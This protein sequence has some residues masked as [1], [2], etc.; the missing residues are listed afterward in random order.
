MNTFT[1]LTHTGISAA[2][3]NPTLIEAHGKLEGAY[4]PQTFKTGVYSTVSNMIPKEAY[5]T[6]I[7]PENAWISPRS[8]N[9]LTISQDE[10]MIPTT[11]S[12]YQLN[13]LDM[14]LSTLYQ[15]QDGLVFRQVLVDLETLP[16]EWFHSFDEFVYEE[17]AYNVLPNTS[18][19]N[20]NAVD[21]IIEPNRGAALYYI[22][23]SANIYGLGG[24]A[25]SKFNFAPNRQALPLILTWLET[26]GNNAPYSAYPQLF[27]KPW[28]KQ[29]YITEFINY[30]DGL[31][32]QQFPNANWTNSRRAAYISKNNGAKETINTQFR[33]EYTPYIDTNILSYADEKNHGDASEMESQQFYN[34]STTVI[35]SEALAELHSRILKRGR[36]NTTILTFLN[37]S[38]D[39]VCALGTLVGDLVL[40]SAQHI[41]HSNQIISDYNFSEYY[42]KLNKFVSVLEQYR[43]FSVPSENIVER[44]FTRNIFANF[45]IASRESVFDLDVMDY[46]T[47]ERARAFEI[48]PENDSARRMI[49][50]AVFY[51]FNNQI[52]Y[53]I[54]FKTNANTG[55]KSEFDAEIDGLFGGV[56]HIEPETYTDENGFMTELAIKLIDDYP[57]VLP[58][59]WQLS[60]SHQLPKVNF[61]QFRI[62]FNENA[63]ILKDPRER[64]R[65]V[66]AI[67]HVDNTQN[68]R[69]TKY[70]PE[71]VGLTREEGG[72]VS[73]EIYL[74]FLD[75]P[76]N[77]LDKVDTTN[78]IQLYNTQN[79]AT[80][81]VNSDKA[82]LLPRATYTA[83]RECKSWAIINEN[84]EVLY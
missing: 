47:D 77:T 69:V 1:T 40:T 44:Q 78:V 10:A 5:K 24:T 43:Q 37:K 19:I 82:I 3:V 15:R 51:P 65:Y 45:E 59:N 31:L 72:L 55:D 74:A 62:F 67:H 29:E 14:R 22:Q 30:M 17:A 21:D 2:C 25:P 11:R 27:S 64:L 56:R 36:G 57:G 52:R 28:V 80:F 23:G 53:E 8:T 12:I 16:Q 18:T 71:A 66:F 4:D 26:F 61:S 34:P 84:Y 81:A 73:E 20:Y 6:I 76:Y 50:P 39:N 13:R 46:L 58:F 60:D 68:G 38:I 48:M 49:L 32:A 33:I 42:A 41:L 35:S 7:E 54:E 83:F 63:T 75:I 70:W 9:G 79:Q